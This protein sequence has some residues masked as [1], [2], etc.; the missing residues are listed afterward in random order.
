[1]TFV[2]ERQPDR[3]VWVVDRERNLILIDKGAS[4][5]DPSR[6]ELRIGEKKISIDAY[7]N[8]TMTGSP[9]SD[10]KWEILRIRFN[11]ATDVEKQKIIQYIKE[12][13]E[14]YGSYGR[15]E[16]TNSVSINFD[17]TRWG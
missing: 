15:P 2:N 6:I 5:G 10:V 12:G 7:N 17:K 13:L 11:N 9:K 3:N 16:K 1:M 8:T 4:D 14:V